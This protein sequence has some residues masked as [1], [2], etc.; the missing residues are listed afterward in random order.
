MSRAAVL[1][2]LALLALPACSSGPADSG[3]LN[4]D[5]VGPSGGVSASRTSLETQQACRQR[6]SEMYDRR[7]RADIYAPNSSMNSPQSANYVEGVTSR[8]LSSQFG[9]EQAISDCE[10]NSGTGAPLP[11]AMPAPAPKVR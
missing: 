8:G 9:Y 2:L 1:P 6:T 11:E 10:R 5:A 3:G 7:N 4:W